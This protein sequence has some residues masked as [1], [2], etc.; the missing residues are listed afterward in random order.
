MSQ[1]Q[2]DRAQGLVA[3]PKRPASRPTPAPVSAEQVRAQVQRAINA[4]DATN[5][6]PRPPQKVSG[7][8]DWHR[9]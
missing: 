8:Q 6:K 1:K 5:T 7:K 9:G 3:I 4:A 2:S